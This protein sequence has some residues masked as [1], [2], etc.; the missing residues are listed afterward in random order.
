MRNW[1]DSGFDMRGVDPSPD[2]LNALIDAASEVEE[3][4]W[5]AAQAAAG[6]DADAARWAANLSDAEFAAL[7]A[8]YLADADLPPDVPFL[9]ALAAYEADQV[10][11]GPQLAGAD[12]AGTV[13]L[14][15]DMAAVDAMLSQ[16]T[17]REHQ[18]QQ[19]DQAERGHRRGSTEVRLANAMRRAGAGTYV[20]GGT[21][22]VGLANDPDIDALFS[23]GPSLNAAEVADRMRYELRGG[24]KPQ[25]RGRFTPPVAALARQIGLR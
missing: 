24:A 3:E 8:E 15:N 22:A 2:E 13:D 23:T 5:A 6:D 12:V 11:P 10:L 21:P 19:E 16:L 18:R 20:Y 1:P 14:A 7:E 25:G 9:E 4:D 17:D